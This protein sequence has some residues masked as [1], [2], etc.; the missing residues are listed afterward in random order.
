MFTVK[1]NQP[2]LKAHIED[3]HLT[4][5]PPQ[6][7]TTDKGHG[8]I[9]VRSIWTSEELNEYLE[10][11]YVRQVFLVRREVTHLGK[12]KQS[13]E[14]AYGITSLTPD[15]ADPARMLELNRGQWS[16]ENRLHWV[17]DVTFDE[18][19]SQIRS[20]NGPRV[21]A[22]LRNL[23]ISMLRICGATNIAKTIRWFG[24]KTHL[25]LRLIGL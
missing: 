18:D 20:G 3:L 13:S 4:D 19:R 11:P 25:A 6:H 9:E 7:Q 17:R 2:T 14:T 23:A 12:N 8:R 16:I 1:D 21:M 22:S 10:F 5:S 24:F 15:K